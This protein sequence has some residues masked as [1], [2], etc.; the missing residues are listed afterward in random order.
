MF[1]LRNPNWSKVE[2]PTESVPVTGQW[3]NITKYIY[4]GAIKSQRF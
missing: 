4:L 3:W 2:C 1:S